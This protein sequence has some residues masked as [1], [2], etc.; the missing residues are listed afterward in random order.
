MKFVFPKEGAAVILTEMCPVAG[1]PYAKQAQE[2][3]QYL[4]SPE[5]QEIIGQREGW[6]PV[7]SKAKLAPAETVGTVYG[8]EMVASMVTVDYGV[9]NPK[10]QEW[11]N[12]WNREVER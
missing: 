5:I 6:G 3:V 11:T 8:E 2:F 10:R 12:R 4:L 7:N 9:I 1:A